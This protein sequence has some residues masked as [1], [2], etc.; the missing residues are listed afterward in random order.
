MAAHD[1]KQ[2]TPCPSRLRIA[3]NHDCTLCKS[4]K[5]LDE[6]IQEDQDL[7]TKALLQGDDDRFE[8]DLDGNRP[9][10]IDRMPIELAIYIFEAYLDEERKKC[11]P[12]VLGAVCRPWRQLVWSTPML[13]T[14]MNLD[15]QRRKPITANTVKLVE[16]WLDRSQSLP[17]NVWLTIASTED[18]S[19]YLSLIDVINKHSS[20]WYSLGL[21]LP[22]D[23]LSRFNDDA[24]PASNL[25][26][27]CLGST[28]PHTLQGSRRG[29]SIKTCAPVVAYLDA[30]FPGIWD[31][32]L[33]NLT[34]ITGLYFQTDQILR[35][36]QLVPML[37]S[38][39]FRE[40]GNMTDSV[41]ALEGR[42]P[43]THCVLRSLKIEFVAAKG[44]FGRDFFDNLTLPVLEEL[45]YAE[46]ECSRSGG[47]GL[48]VNGLRSFLTR[49]SCQLKRLDVTGKITMENWGPLQGL[50]PNIA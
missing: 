25:K 48:S 46:K 20:R 49:S 1:K 35:I 16:D 37:E 12:L 4:H 30:A 6:Q 10:I 19:R 47:R 22:N 17:L 43:V 23:L 21:V 26:R 41:S 29:L 5:V 18:D 8:Q 38:I 45:S 13:W 3:Q 28:V 32:T 14:T 24:G 33:E 7:R 40:T 15:F 39:G 27:L 50:V 2:E 31:V 44:H 42:L 34:Q 9:S 11:S 36:L